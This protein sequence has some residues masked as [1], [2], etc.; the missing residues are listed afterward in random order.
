MGLGVDDRVLA[1]VFL[2]GKHVVQERNYIILEIRAN[3]YMLA[4]RLVKGS[5]TIVGDET[6]SF[7]LSQIAWYEMKISWIN[8]PVLGTLLQNSW[9]EPLTP[10]M[11]TALELSFSP[12]YCTDPQARSVY[13]IGTSTNRK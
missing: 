13:T 6:L 1:R 2:L 4:E 9:Y 10:F 5:S 8:I 7:L 12:D 3:N 11:L